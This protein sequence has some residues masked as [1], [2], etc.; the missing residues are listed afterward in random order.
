MAGA[1]ELTTGTGAIRI[2]RVDGSATIKSS[3]GDTWVGEVVGDVQVKAANG[4]I[5]AE[6]SSGAHPNW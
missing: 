4:R 2:D 5:T 3:N 6:R 1:T